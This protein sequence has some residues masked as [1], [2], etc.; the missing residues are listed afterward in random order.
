MWFQC[1]FKRF[2]KSGSRH[3]HGHAPSLQLASEHVKACWACSLTLFHVFFKGMLRGGDYPTLALLGTGSGG[4]SCFGGSCWGHFASTSCF[5]SGE[6]L[7]N[8]DHLQVVAAFTACGTK[9]HERPFFPWCF[10]PV[11]MRSWTKGATSAGRPMVILQPEGN[12]CFGISML[13]AGNR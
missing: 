8:H 12:R 6:R 5:L 1:S 7:S 9:L 2:P 10:S 11:T 13:C 4:S 3:A